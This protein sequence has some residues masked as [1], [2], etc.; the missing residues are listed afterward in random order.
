VSEPPRDAPPR[1]QKTA[2]SL[3]LVNTGEGKGK[4]TAAFGTAMRAAGRGWP[5]CV[6]QFLKSDRWKTGEEQAARTLGIDWWTLGDGFTWDSEDMERS[7][8]VARVAW[9]AAVAKIAGGDYRL[10]VLDE[11]TYPVT[12]GWIDEAD[13]VDAIRA[14]PPHVS[15]IVTGRD[16]TRA[17]VELA[18]TVTEM[19]KRKH[20]FD[21]GITAL[22][23]IEF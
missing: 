17:I 1:A 23:G 18:D 6:I 14:R 5:V 2:S 21:A 20:A 16:A 15:V 13:L 3:V 22:A 9:D 19:V 4:S 11:V 12:W 7:E 10:V 8:A